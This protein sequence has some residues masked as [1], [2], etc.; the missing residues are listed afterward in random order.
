LHRPHAPLLLL[1][2][3]GV[4]GELRMLPCRAHTTAPTGRPAA[5]TVHKLLLLLLNPFPCCLLQD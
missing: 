2:L 1:L 5:T 4:R 3:R